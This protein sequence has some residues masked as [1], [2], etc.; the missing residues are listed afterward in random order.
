MKP[1]KN[2]LFAAT[3]ILCLV[4]GLNA[5]EKE[6]EENKWGGDA[7]VGLA[8]ARGNTETTNLSLTFSAKGPLSKAV[9]STNKAYFLLSKEKDITNAESMGLESYIQWK[10]SEKL[11]S[12]YGIQGIRDRFK[13]YSY[14][15]LPGLGLGYKIFAEENL[16][17]SASAGLSQLFIKYF[18]SEETDSYTGFSLGNEFTWK[19]S[20]TAEVSQALNIN[21]DISEPSHYFLQFDISL[22]SAITKGLSVKLT[23]MDKYDSKPVGEGIK[24]NDISFIAGLSAKF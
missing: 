2:K 6:N 10:H 4:L 11:F 20:P 12:Y 14:R 22:A 16:Q 24:K 17:L 13:N 21:A 8:L 19:V 1:V 18:D 3:L 5:Q 23:L 7:A 15:I 9:D